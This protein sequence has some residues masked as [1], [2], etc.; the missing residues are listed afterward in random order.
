[1]ASR[2]S[3]KKQERFHGFKPDDIIQIKKNKAV[4]ELAGIDGIQQR[5]KV[6]TRRLLQTGRQSGAR[7]KH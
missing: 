7:S 1:M 6:V 2:A 3:A 5:G 4:P